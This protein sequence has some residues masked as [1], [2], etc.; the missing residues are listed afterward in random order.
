MRYVSEFP[1]QPKRGHDPM[2]GPS[3]IWLVGAEI[4][5]ACTFLLVMVIG[6]VM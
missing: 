2:E 6:L 3:L 4:A 5:V 1:G